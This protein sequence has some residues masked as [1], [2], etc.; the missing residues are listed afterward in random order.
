MSKLRLLTLVFFSLNLSV[1]SGQTR[2]SVAAVQNTTGDSVSTVSEKIKSKNSFERYTETFIIN[3]Q[4]NS[5]LVTAIQDVFQKMSQVQYAS[6]EN[7]Y[8]NEKL[9]VKNIYSLEE[10]NNFLIKKLNETPIHKDSIL[11]VQAFLD[12]YKTIEKLSSDTLYKLVLSN[13]RSGSYYPERLASYTLVRLYFNRIVG[14]NPPLYHSNLIFNLLNSY[15][16]ESSFNHNMF[17]KQTINAKTKS[18]INDQYLILLYEFWKI[19]SKEST[20]DEYRYYVKHILTSFFYLDKIRRDNPDFNRICTWISKNY[21]YFKYYSDDIFSSMPS[22]PSLTDEM[23]VIVQFAW[24]NMLASNGIQEVWDNYVG[25]NIYETSRENEIM[26][27]IPLY[28]YK[29]RLL[30][31]L[32]KKDLIFSIET[33][34]QNTCIKSVFTTFGFPYQAQ[35]LFMSYMKE[36]IHKSERKLL[37]VESQQEVKLKEAAENNTGRT[38]TEKVS[39]RAKF[40]NNDVML[41]YMFQRNKNSHESLIKHAFSEVSDSIKIYNYVNIKDAV[42]LRLGWVKDTAWMNLISKHINR[43]S[44]MSYDSIFYNKALNPNNTRITQYMT[45]TENEGKESLDSLIQLFT[46]NLNNEVKKAVPSKSIDLLKKDLVSYVEGVYT[47]ISK[48]SLKDNIL[49]YGEAEHSSSASSPGSAVFSI[50]PDG[51]A[52]LNLTIYF[53]GEAMYKYLNGKIVKLSNGVYQFASTES[54]F[55][56]R[57]NVDMCGKK[58]LELAGVG[59]NASIKAILKVE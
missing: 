19:K 40:S 59:Q 56:F 31:K 6:G 50:Y 3:E 57:Y 42:K 58:T 52:S 18:Y 12:E 21:H 9:T 25:E 7:P 24:L 37:F 45:T 36:P 28:K 22:K 23:G 17:F 16:I 26:R 47:S 55:N 1:L 15:A 43:V 39:S 29:L 4:Q 10:I 32:P 51:K 34:T 2:N 38:I 54:A 49:L 41:Y 11:A 35:V 33:K 27:P 46:I 5:D 30:K 14:L 8:K 48:K 20:I 13:I 44:S 53:N